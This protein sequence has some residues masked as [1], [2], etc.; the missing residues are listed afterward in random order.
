MMTTGVNKTRSC[1]CKPAKVFASLQVILI[2]FFTFPKKMGRSDDGK[3]NIL[4]GWP[5]MFF[6]TDQRNESKTLHCKKKPFTGKILIGNAVNI[7]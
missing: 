2:F 7:N 6:S 5:Y 4:W 3:R 1:A